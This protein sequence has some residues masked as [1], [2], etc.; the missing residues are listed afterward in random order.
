[1]IPIE[2]LSDEWD[3]YVGSPDHKP[4]WLKNVFYDPEATDTAG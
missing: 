2:S 1:L 4:A 3:D